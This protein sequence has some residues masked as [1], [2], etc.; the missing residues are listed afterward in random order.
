MTKIKI[1]GITNHQDAQVAAGLGVDALGFVFYKASPRYVKPNL[2]K[3]I[4]AA[5]P[6]F[7]TTVGVFVDEEAEVIRQISHDCCLQVVQLHG[8][9]PPD[10][11]RGF[12]NKVIKA[13]RIKDKLS[14][15]DIDK[16][17]VDALLLDTYQTDKFGGTGEVFNWELASEAKKHARIILAGG[18]NPENIQQALKSV[19]PY[20][21]DVSSGVEEEPGKKD[22]DK[23]RDLVERVRRLGC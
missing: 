10:F 22:A 8:H 17:P 20:A 7:I 6:P 21:V 18:L 23:L 16:Y 3:D 12:K 14:L 4:I 13:I 11:C 2:A 5:L 1:C 19:N 9:E 15:I